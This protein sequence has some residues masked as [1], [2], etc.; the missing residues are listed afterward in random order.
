MHGFAAGVNDGY[1]AAQGETATTLPASHDALPLPS[2]SRRLTAAATTCQDIYG[3]L[4]T[5][6]NVALSG[7][8]THA[9]AAGFLQYVLY[10][11]T[12][13]GFVKQSFDALV[14]GIVEVRAHPPTTRCTAAPP[15][16]ARQHGQ[17]RQHR[18]H[19]TLP[20]RT[21]RQY[22]QYSTQSQP[23]PGLATHAAANPLQS[24]A[25]P[26]VGIT[27]QALRNGTTSMYHSITVP[28]YILGCRSTSLYH[29]TQNCVFRCFVNYGPPPHCTALP[30]H[31][32]TQ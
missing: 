30:H 23:Q 18:Q 19:N 25:Q 8:H 28:H 12:S 5:A 24:I 26:Y 13:L 17:H 22:W 15:T 11:I 4:Y 16:A 20:C 10:S 2:P 7:T 21:G 14:D 6:N 32:P 1:I 31:G 27:S 29:R 9:S 3:G